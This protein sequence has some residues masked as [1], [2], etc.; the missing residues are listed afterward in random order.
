MGIF[1]GKTTQWKRQTGKQSIA[2]NMPIALLQELDSIKTV[3]GGTRTAMILS[4]IRLYIREQKDMM[5]DQERK[6]LEDYR[7]RQQNR[8]R[9]VNTGLLP[10]Y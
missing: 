3:C 9:Q 7:I 2:I 4:G 1:G 6:A 5:A 10:D 8:N